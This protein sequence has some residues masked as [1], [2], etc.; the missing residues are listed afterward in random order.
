MSSNLKRLKVTF[1][2]QK[3]RATTGMLNDSE[4]KK[5]ALGLC[6]SMPAQSLFSPIRP[7]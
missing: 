4:W 5:A 2:M 3:G 6:L 7:V 1:Q